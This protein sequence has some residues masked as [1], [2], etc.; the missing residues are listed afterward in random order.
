[1]GTIILN[2]DGVNSVTK[3]IIATSTRPPSYKIHIRTHGKEICNITLSDKLIQQNWMLSIESNPS[4]AVPLVG[5]STTA[6]ALLHQTYAYLMVG[7]NLVVWHSRHVALE[8][9]IQY[10]TQR[11]IATAHK[12]MQP[13]GEQLENST[14]TSRMINI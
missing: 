13:A 11:H 10:F 14:A 3:W 2:V 4:L 5:C 1:M 7:I 8:I 12:K 6:A 9:T